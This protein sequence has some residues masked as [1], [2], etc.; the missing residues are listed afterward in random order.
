MKK[1][2]LGAVV[3]SL[4]LML[5]ACAAGNN[6]TPAAGG[7]TTAK[8][9]KAPMPEIPAGLE[10]FYKQRV[11]WSECGKNLECGK[12]MVPLD[13]KNPTSATIAIAAKKHKAKGKAIGSLLVNPGGPG[14]SG[15]EMAEGAADYF[16]PDILANFDIIGFDP[17]GVD[18]SAPVDCL[19]DKDLA[20]V[21]DAS[22]PDTAEGRAAARVDADKV[23]A[24]CQEKSGDL[25]PFVGTESAARDMDVLR[26]V[27]GDPQL[28]YVGY[29]YGT[30]LGGMYAELFPK[31]V[32]RMV[33]D[34]AVSSQVSS[35]QQTVAQLQGFEKALDAYLDD[36]LDGSSCPFTGSK[37]QARAQIKQLFADTLQKPLPTAS[38]GRQLTQSALFIGM[39][40][41]LYDDT[42]WPLLTQAFQEAF[43]KQR[44]TLFLT[45]ADTYYSRTGNTFQDNS[46]EA[47]WAINCADYPAQG[48][49]AQW[50][51]EATE[52]K[53]KA[54]IF[55]EV[56]GYDEY[57]CA[58]WPYKAPA[59]IG[60]FRAEGSNSIVVV[61]TTGDPATPYQWA[62][63]FSKTLANAVLITWEGEGHTA[64]GR[65]T[66]CVNK[67]ID[68][69]LLDGTVPEADL[70][71]PA[72]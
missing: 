53:E 13:Y 1:H 38:E 20:Q 34:G 2:Q 66:D 47:N 50:Q 22:Y 60:P 8:A 28:Y 40:T 11:V 6:S 26:H 54:P 59:P 56:A 30:S 62:V 16:S 19:A 64:Y 55:G 51:A 68:K 65:S 29:S 18:K 21:V 44:G 52:L 7:A 46:V 35:F 14:A 61:G 41:P 31:N 23:V 48:D 63:D 67:P 24:G 58:K 45:M 17:R 57:M 15:Q 25:L 27:L 72:E 4:L 42:L 36:C 39:I 3:I 5:S 49:D 71:C 37:E 9:I 69:Y 43:T 32:G 10:S 33:L 12:F 70:K